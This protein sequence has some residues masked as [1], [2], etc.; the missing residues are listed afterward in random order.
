MRNFKQSA[1]YLSQIHPLHMIYH[2]S[3][4]LRLHYNSKEVTD[5][6]E[7]LEKIAPEVGEGHTFMNLKNSS[8][9]YELKKTKRI[10][11]NIQKEDKK[12]RK[13]LELIIKKSNN[14]EINA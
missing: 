13:K 4:F 3:D 10:R 1:R 12:I 8:L 5:L 14:K 6:Y 11:K 9:K 2:Y 7:L